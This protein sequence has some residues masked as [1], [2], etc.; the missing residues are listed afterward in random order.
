MDNKL[1]VFEYD[2]AEIRTVMID[3]EVWFVGKDVA[4]VL[5]YSNTRD[6][7]IEHVDEED[8]RVIQ[9]SENATLGLDVPNRGLTVINE[10]GL[11]SLILSS[12]LPTARKFKHWVT[13][14]V[15]PQIHHTGGYSHGSTQGTFAI[16][17]AIRILEHHGIE[18]NQLTLALDKVY[19]R[20]TGFSMLEVTGIALPA[21]T[22]HQILTPTEIGSE[23]GLSAR[24]VND[25]LAGAGFQYKVADKWEPL[26]AGKPYAV[27][28]DTGRRHSDGTPIRQLKWDSGILD[29]FGEMLGQ[30]E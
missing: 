19:K 28:L 4:T 3:G 9:K 7:L 22:Q 5:G 2:G 26:D 15:L 10:S 6:A 14:E 20:C 25:I 1:Q 18:G 27:M 13:S 16:D 11:Y 30:S 12:Q 8:R 24:R 29:A 23:Y 21:P 17:A